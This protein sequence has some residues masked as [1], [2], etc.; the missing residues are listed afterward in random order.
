MKT[1][2]STTLLTLSITASTLLT[3]CFQKASLHKASAP[4]SRTAAAHPAAKNQH[5]KDNTLK[6]T[7]VF[8]YEKTPKDWSTF[9]PQTLEIAPQQGHA[10]PF[11]IETT[12]TISGRTVNIYKNTDQGTSLVS[13]ATPSE[14]FGIL[15]LPEGDSLEIHATA[16]Q[17]TVT[18]AAPLIC[19]PSDDI[20]T[21]DSGDSGPEAHFTEENAKDPDTPIYVDVVVFYNNEAKANLGSHSTIE[22]KYI[23]QLTAAN[24]ILTNSHI[25]N[26]QWRYV[27]C[28]HLN[29]AT[30][31]KNIDDDLFKPAHIAEEAQFIINTTGADLSITITGIKDTYAGVALGTQ[32]VVAS[33]TGYYTF[34]HEL[35]HGFGCKHDRPTEGVSD[36]DG[37]YHY[38]Y[39]SNSLDAGTIMSYSYNKLPYFSSH[40]LLYKGIPLG[41]PENSPGAANNARTL[42]EYAAIVANQKSSSLAPQIIDQPNDIAAKQNDIINLGVLASGNNL[43]YTFVH[44]GT[45]V[46]PSINSLHSINLSSA[47][48]GVWQI[49]VSN[50]IDKITTNPF[51]L[52]I[53]DTEV[54]PQI[55][56]LSPNVAVK[57]G[58]YFTLQVIPTTENDTQYQWFKDGEP[59]NANRHYFQKIANPGDAGSYHVT[60]SNQFG[61]T[62]SPS[63]TVSLA[64]DAPPP[65]PVIVTA[66]NDNGYNPG[67]GTP[68]GENNGTSE[69]N[70][71]NG[72]G[73]GSPSLLW[74]TA[75]TI[76]AILKRHPQKNTH[77]HP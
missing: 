2:F 28:H 68:N 30:G 61:S 70:K 3:G 73:G 49:I 48:I 40:L 43:K 6:I 67:N 45:Q 52:S 42:R 37:K 41:I 65:S 31:T 76:L 69:T 19:A 25:F 75:F 7:D 39:H 66:D 59:I 21:H 24:T 11:K 10:V 60:V 74:L 13:A 8:P 77:A 5:E 47:T 72:G 36:T 44:N 58:N 62:I 14:Y 63:I 33:N 27:G 22:T 71:S 50:E 23:A 32:S 20:P 51:T 34:A 46:A 9:S 29:Y 35:A 64:H 18:T 55:A 17:I 16:N 1:I 38:G 53:G 54:P 12:K 57:E 26:F 15:T 56:Y 4:T